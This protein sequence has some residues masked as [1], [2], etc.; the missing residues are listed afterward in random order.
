[1]KQNE[2]QWKLINMFSIEES[3]SENIL[4]QPEDTSDGVFAKGIRTWLKKCYF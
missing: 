3:L 2:T 1:M 4:L